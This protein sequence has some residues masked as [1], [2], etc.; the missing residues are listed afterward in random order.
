MFDNVTDHSYLVVFII[1]ACDK[2]ELSSAVIVDLMD[3]L[4][5]CY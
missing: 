3:C 1:P 2:A 5:P 4:L